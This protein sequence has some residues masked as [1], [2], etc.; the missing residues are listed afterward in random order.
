MSVAQQRTTRG[1]TG[2]DMLDA[3]GLIHMWGRIYDARLGRFIQADPIVQNGVDLH[4]YNRYAYVRNNP[5]TLTD[6]SG[7]SFLS[8]AWKGLK[9]GLSKACCIVRNTR[10]L[11]RKGGFRR[12]RCG[13]GF[14]GA[15]KFVHPTNLARCGEMPLPAWNPLQ[16]WPAQ[17]WAA[18]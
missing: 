8:K 12:D 5:L 2:H 7:F 4:A 1:Y 9:K 15:M 10:S 18:M 11:K 14:G 6:P 17:L 3:V 16:S 13:I